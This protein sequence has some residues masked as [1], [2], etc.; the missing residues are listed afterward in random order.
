[1]AR[2]CFISQIQATVDFVDFLGF[3]GHFGKE[4]GDPDFEAKFDLDNSG[5]VDFTD[6]L[7]F[8]QAF[9]NSG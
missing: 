5:S 6:F 2:A 1:M 8:A 4:Q 7:Q 3:A 9:G